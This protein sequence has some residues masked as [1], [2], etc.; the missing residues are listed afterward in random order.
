MIVTTYIS[1]V[2]TMLFWGGTFIAGR[3]LAGSVSPAS[4]AFLRFVIAT[5]ALAVLTRMIHGRIPIP[6][7][8]QWLSLLL[9]GM[10]GIVSYNILFFIGMQHIEAGRASLIIALNPLAITIAAAIFLDEKLSFMQFGGILISL[11]GALFVISNGHPWS[12]FS[13]GFGIG[14]ASILGCVASWTAYSLIGRNVLKILS[15]LVSVFYSSLIGTLLLFPFALNNNLTT[16]I[17]TYS[18]YDWVSLTFLGLL[19][20]AVGVSFYYR[21]IQKIGASRS[22][23]FINLV[24]FFSILLSWLM[25]GEAMKFSVLSGGLL[26]LTGVY[27]TNRLPK[28]QSV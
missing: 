13:G 7:W 23:V 9:L 19:G 26:L 5:L 8:K 6:S 25:L 10:T 2:V 27:L 20:T 12:I 14:E 18:I 17:L 4:A 24:P 21:A 3:I 16:D 11:A 22:S 1:L 15:P 28:K